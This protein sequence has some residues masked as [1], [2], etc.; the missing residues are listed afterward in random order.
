MEG[1]KKFLVV[2][3]VF[4]VVYGLLQL[5]FFKSIDFCNL[6]LATILYVLFSF[7]TEICINRR[8]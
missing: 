6:I 7:I 4:F 2:A 5:L 1:L 8:C 3:A